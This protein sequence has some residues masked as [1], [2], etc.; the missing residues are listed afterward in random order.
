MDLLKI[1][2]ESTEIDKE[3]VKQYW[4]SNIQSIVQGIIN[5]EI[6]GLIETH[7]CSDYESHPLFK[8]LRDE[9]RSNEKLLIQ[10]HICL[11]FLSE[12][13]CEWYPNFG[14]PIYTM[15]LRQPIFGLN[16]KMYF[17]DDGL[18]SR[19][20]RDNRSFYH[21]KDNIEDIKR[22]AH[23]HAVRVAFNENRCP[24]CFNPIKTV[25]G[26]FKCL[27]CWLSSSKL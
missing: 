17:D 22:I 12:E 21:I 18:F 20:I 15:S 9:G 8:A 2:E 13:E 26:K 5:D 1:T 27:N 10:H 24:K 4:E 11:H 14:T 7:R 23:D 16:K 6:T 3:Q 25:F 19:T